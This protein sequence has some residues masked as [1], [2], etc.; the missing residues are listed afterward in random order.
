MLHNFVLTIY[1]FGIMFS[2]F[3][4]SV[5]S[6]PS[7][8]QLGLLIPPDAHFLLPFV[9]SPIFTTTHFEVPTF[10]LSMDIT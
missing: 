3:N 9:P 2:H 6:N 1:C 5:H 8:I 10:A 7:P 4:E